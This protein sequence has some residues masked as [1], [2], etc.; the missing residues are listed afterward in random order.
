MWSVVRD[1]ERETGVYD[2]VGA[3]ETP[4]HFQGTSVQIY[5][6]LKFQGFLNLKQKCD[7]IGLGV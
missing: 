5:H 4:V 3:R 2:A 7:F 1:F 6:A